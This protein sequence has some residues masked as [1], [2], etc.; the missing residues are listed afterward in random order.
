[1]IH[2]MGRATVLAIA[3]VGLATGTAFAHEEREVGD[4]TFAVGF[5]DEPVFVGQK[6]GLRVLRQP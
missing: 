6:S 1:M 4:H 5:I 2:R 3:L